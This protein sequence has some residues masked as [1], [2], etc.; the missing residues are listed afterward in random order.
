M[1]LTGH[2]CWSFPLRFAGKQ[3]WGRQTWPVPSH[4]SL[5]HL[6]FIASAPLPSQHLSSNSVPSH[7][8]L[9]PSGLL[10]C[11]DISPSPH[12]SS[13]STCPMS[14]QTSPLTSVSCH[15][16]PLHTSLLSH[17]SP[18]PQHCL[19]FLRPGLPYMS[20][21]PLHL[22]PQHH[23][24]IAAPS[25]LSPH[26]CPLSTAPSV[27]SPHTC[28]L[29]TLSSALSPHRCPLTPVPPPLP[30]PPLPAAPHSHW[31]QVFPAAPPPA[32]VGRDAAAPQVTVPALRL[33]AGGQG[34]GRDWL[35]I[36]R[37][38]R[39]QA[40]MLPRARGAEPGQ[41]LRGAGGTW[42]GT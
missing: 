6:A 21:S 8:S 28:P 31:L 41:R 24:F 40:A 1:T 18:V 22:S 7:L 27:L 3:L 15:T 4:L 17:L 30:Q 2:H 26:T 36:G 11:P 16:C 38:S 14:P 13:L 39:P 25:A 10:L 34:P 42:G 29:S 9:V 20:P 33:A 12:T 35:P 23:P 32:L 37:G 19:L 5:Q